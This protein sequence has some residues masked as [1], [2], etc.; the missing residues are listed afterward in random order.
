[1]K[2][3]IA[4]VGK[5]KEKYLTEAV[6]EYSKRLTRY[7]RPEILEVAD[8]S[9]PEKASEAQEQASRDK[10]GLR[11]LRQIPENAWVITCEIGGK[12]PDSKEFAALLQRWM[13]EG[14]SHLVF[15]IGGSTGLSGDICRRSDYALSFSR[16]TFPHQLM[17]VILLE[18]I[19]RAFR[20]NAGEPYHK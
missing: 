8:E 7:C 3:S 11:L 14:K 16:M 19:Y 12:T 6:R 2:I 17:R 20:I 18:Q 10:E 15:V 5:L 9:I 1:M 4:C 13:S